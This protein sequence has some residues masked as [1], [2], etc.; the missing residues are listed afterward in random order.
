MRKA[1]NCHHTAGGYK[2]KN[3]GRKEGT[4]EEITRSKNW[5]KLSSRSRSMSMTRIRS[6]SRCMSMSMSKK[7]DRCLGI[8]R[9]N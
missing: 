8:D 7:R 4:N 6:R 1:E 3:E 5:G 2:V 9:D